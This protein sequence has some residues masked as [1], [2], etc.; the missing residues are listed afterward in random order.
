MGDKR[1]KKNST[2]HLDTWYNICFS[3]N[4]SCS[5]GKFKWLKY[6]IKK[7]LSLKIYAKLEQG[8]L[9]SI[10]LRLNHKALI[11]FIMLMILG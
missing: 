7:Q 5:S 1:E 11:M 10:P 2:E 4:Q 9:K 3:L 8:N 6:Q